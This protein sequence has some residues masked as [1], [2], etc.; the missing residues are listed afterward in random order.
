MLS[1]SKMSLAVA[2]AIAIGNNAFAD[3]TVAEDNK[4]NKAQDNTTTNTDGLKVSTTIVEDDDKIDPEELS[5]FAA[6]TVLRMQS[7]TSKKYLKNSKVADVSTFPMRLVTKLSQDPWQKAPN[8]PFLA[9]NEC[10]YGTPSYR[11]PKIYDANKEPITVTADAVHGSL[12]DKKSQKL[13]YTG[14]VAIEQGDKKITSDTAVYSAT[15]KTITTKG[16]NSRL[17]SG[18]YTV[19]TEEDVVTNVETKVISL[20]ESNYQFN[21]SLL[22]GTAK[23][24]VNDDKKKHKI[25]KKATIST[26]P[27]ERRSW[28]LW[29]STIEM[30]DGD[31]FGDS[32][33]DVL[34]IGDV[35]VFYTPY[36]VFPITNERRSGILNAAIGY[37]SADG[38]E[39]SLPIYLNLAPN[40]DLTLT[41]EYDADHKNIYNA[42]FRYM[43]F[44]NFNGTL[45]VTYLP[46]D[47]E[48]VNDSNEKKRWFFNIKQ[49]AFFLDNDLNILVDYSKVRNND[50]TYLTDISQKDAAVTDSSLLQT[51]KA[52]YDQKLYR[53][54]FEVRKYHNMFSKT[55]FSTFRPFAMMP[56][57]KFNYTD[58]YNSLSYSVD[59]EITRFNLDKMVENKD[60]NIN[61]LHLEPAVKYL[62]Y[63]AYGSSASV[64][65]TGFLTHYTQSD[66]KYMPGSYY[67][68]LGYDKYDNNVTRALFLFEASGKT[69]LE[70][71]VLDMNHTQTLEPEI[72]Y[73]YIP[74]RDQSN[75]GL[76]DTTERYDDYYTLFS[77]HRYAGIDRIADQ[78]SFTLGLT[79]KLLDLHDRE[80]IKASVAQRYDIRTQRVKLRPTEEERQRRSPLELMIDAVPFDEITFHADT[81]YDH[82]KGEFYCFN[83]SLHYNNPNQY[84]FGIS[85]RY[86]RNGNYIVNRKSDDPDIDL[87]QLGLEATIPL[88]NSW[89]IIAAKY[90]DLKQSYNIDTKFGLKYEDCCYSIA[91]V[92]ENYMEMDW[93]NMT[94]KDKKFTGIRF[95][96]KGLY[97][98]EAKGISNPNSTSTHYI[99]STDLTNLNR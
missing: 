69:T 99:P 12:T 62:A 60:V 51:V 82:Y 22:N 33:N 96:L 14:N 86:Y 38:F 2:L 10:F 26:C 24:L 92:H 34:F 45:N 87:Q 76:Y 1:I 3:N 28:H 81:R 30:Q 5:I 41:P 9:K 78:N 80:V 20:G 89:S 58:T 35:P 54:T 29:S 44:K 25:F 4:N 59:S 48:W 61:R 84:N 52:I 15:T 93:A 43:P 42:E 66:L 67:D 19:T 72:K 31:S 85:Y 70:R 64:G 17:S 16:K 32:W 6:K 73:Q 46:D 8:L 55:N 77:S 27:I 95:E 39:G 50:Y 40:Y 11:A 98:M 79:S 21:G 7:D 91:F 37:N 36:A 49:R 71:K 88:S 47:P 65:L 23:S 74:Y 75:I 68:R 56:Q 57:L 97:T 63:D 83:T 18:E 94:H 13:T 53:A 90:M